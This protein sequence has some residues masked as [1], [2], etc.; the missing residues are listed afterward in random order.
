MGLGSY[1]LFADDYYRGRDYDRRDYDRRDSERRDY[2][3]D[4]YYSRSRY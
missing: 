2:R 1:F 3:E 4:R